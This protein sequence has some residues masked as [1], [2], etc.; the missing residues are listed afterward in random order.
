MIESDCNGGY[1]CVCVRERERERDWQLTATMDIH[2]E[3]LIDRNVIEH[4][5][6]KQTEMG[7]L[8]KVISK[9]FG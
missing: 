6:F 8:D 7:E 5:N 3:I 4:V 9:S 2:L 1:V